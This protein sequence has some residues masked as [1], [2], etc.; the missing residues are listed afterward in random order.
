LTNRLPAMMALAAAM[1]ALSGGWGCIY[2]IIWASPGAAIVL[3]A[4]FIFFLVF[5]FAPQRGLL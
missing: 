5:L 3:T 1:A 2:R 4:T